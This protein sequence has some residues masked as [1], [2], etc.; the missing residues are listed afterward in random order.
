M[1]VA[2]RVRL[3]TALIAVGVA[4][5]FAAVL[6]AVAGANPLT[7]ARA[8]ISGAFGNEYSVS[9]TL[10][11]S[12]PLI[13]IG[14]GSAIAFRAGI[15]NLGGEG[16]LYVGGL[17]TA[18]V[19]LHAHGLPT[20]VLLPLMAV[21]A[22]AA[23]AGW[24]LIAGFLRNWRGAS[25]IITTIM[26]NY[27][28]IYLTQYFLHGP[29]Q[30][31]GATSFGETERLPAA[32][33]LPD[34]LPGTV[35][36]IGFA[37]AVVAAIVFQFLLSDTSWGFRV[38]LVGANRRAATAAGVDVAR[39]GLG[40]FAVGGALA[41]LAGFCAVS[42]TTGRMIDNISPGYGYVAIVVALLGANLPI[43]VLVAGILMAALDSGSITMQ[44]V[45]G[46][47]SSV[48]ECIQYL[49]VILVIARAAI[50][51]IRLR[52]AQVQQVQQVQQGEAS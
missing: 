33:R 12:V 19:G 52:R 20:A 15:F 41:G 51:P 3:S 30:A 39:V 23:G 25:E 32:A 35:L 26:L 8:L 47:P 48:G 10:V 34:L 29:L 1:S 4:L 18:V 44:S 9:T 50:T 28:G 5:V 46:V 40:V 17:V 36:H 24:S 42:G 14:V 6:V 21:A 43:G 45:S 16:Q 49:I 27:V 7:A 22:A 13:L 37:L 38:R 31:P 2:L 11:D